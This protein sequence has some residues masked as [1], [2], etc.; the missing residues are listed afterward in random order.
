MALE[1]TPFA[2]SGW[3]LRCQRLLASRE[4]TPEGPAGTPGGTWVCAHLGA[5][6]FCTHSPGKLLH[7]TGR[8][9]RGRERSFWA[10]SAGRDAPTV[11]ATE[12][13]LGETHL[14]VFC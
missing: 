9:G 4:G 13:E 2:V 14:F 5:L 7:Q 1:S 8:W 6:A 11:G 10:E 12:G 3:G